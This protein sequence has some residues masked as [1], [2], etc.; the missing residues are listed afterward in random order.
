M[1]NER[2]RTVDILRFIAIV[3]I[4]VAHASP[5]ELL[6]RIRNFDVVLMVLLMG[7]S[8][9][10]SQKENSV[11]YNSYILKRFK[12]LIIST[13]IF[14]IV[15][16]ALFF[17]ISLFSNGT[18]FFDIKTIVLSFAFNGGIG[19]VWI[20][21]VFFVV[22]L[23]SPLILQLGEKI[24]NNNKYFLSLIFLYIIYHFL[25]S[26]NGLLPTI[27]GE[28]LQNYI[29]TPLGYCL[30]AAVGIRFKSLNKKEILIM[31]GG[32]LSTF[33]I[34]MLLYKFKSTQDFKYPPTIY[35]ISYGLFVSFILYLIFNK[36]WVQKLFFN[37]FLYFYSKLSLNL[38]FFHIFS[39]YILN[40]YGEHLPLVS[41][42]F[43]TR[44]LFI[45]SSAML[46]TY[47]YEFLITNWLKRRVLRN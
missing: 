10:I 8:F 17:V 41:K 21:Y 12:R 23:F 11:N 24:E 20:M 35:Y 43:I 25:V 9:T 16:F 5:N 31:V 42:Y 36:P 46:M 19:Y 38:Y 26:L 45:I 6:F 47:L 37:R 1:S 4:V 14:L 18:L 22:S 7:I 44:F 29:F 13:W 32:F 39:I 15:F 33:L 27:L 2:N 30:I 3:S 28:N 40:F 34:F